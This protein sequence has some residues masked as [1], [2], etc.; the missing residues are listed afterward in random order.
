MRTTPGRAWTPEALARE[1]RVDRAWADAQLRAF[2]AARLVRPDP[3]HDGAGPAPADGRSGG[4]G[5]EGGAFVFAP[6]TPDLERDVT[7][8]AQ[9]YLLHRV[10]VIEIIYAARPS[11]AVQSFADAFRLRR[12]PPHG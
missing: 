12:D 6:A 8:A 11:A 9:A 4:G 1:L 3:P 2:A 7:A 10:R 5:G